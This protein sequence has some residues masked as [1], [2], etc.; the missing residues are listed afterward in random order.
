MEAADLIRVIEGDPVVD[1]ELLRAT[2]NWLML[3]VGRD[4]REREFSMIQV[5]ATRSKETQEIW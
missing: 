1:K 2:Q 3:V 4:L 5:S